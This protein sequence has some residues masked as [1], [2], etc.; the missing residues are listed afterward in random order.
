MMWV[1]DG[2]RQLFD[3]PSVR[4]H[5]FKFVKV[6]PKR[7]IYYFYIMQVFLNCRR[8]DGGKTAVACL[9]SFAWNRFRHAEGMISGK[10]WAYI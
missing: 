2:L 3:S 5:G 7:P 6:C 1:L 4:R 9:G 8:S 10:T